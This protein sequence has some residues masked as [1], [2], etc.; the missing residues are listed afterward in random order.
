MAVKYND[1]NIVIGG[2]KYVAQYYPWTSAGSWWSAN[3]M[4]AVVD[5]GAS[6]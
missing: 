4:N 5:K 1:P 6:V 3:K 2:A